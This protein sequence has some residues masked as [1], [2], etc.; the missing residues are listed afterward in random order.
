MDVYGIC[1]CGENTFHKDNYTYCCIE[2]NETCETQSMF[3][4]FKRYW[5]T[6]SEF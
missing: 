4:E 1:E 2:M 3:Y 6:T 5:L